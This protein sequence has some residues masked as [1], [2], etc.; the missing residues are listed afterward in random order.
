MYKPTLTSRNS[1]VVPPGP[2][3]VATSGVDWK[4]VGVLRRL[5]KLERETDSRAAE[6]SQRKAA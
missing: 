2:A 6:R 5:A 3:E 4:R 1:S